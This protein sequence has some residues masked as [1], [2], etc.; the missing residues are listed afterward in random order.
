MQ[1]F[2]NMVIQPIKQL[3]AD[4]TTIIEIYDVMFSVKRGLT[5]HIKDKFYGFKVGQKCWKTQK[6]VLR[7]QQSKVLNAF[8][9]N[10]L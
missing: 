4:Y 1:N 3:E 6:K 5:D 10:T 8:K 2:M 9:L 7:R